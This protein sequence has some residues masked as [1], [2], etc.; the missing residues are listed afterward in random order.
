MN[1]YEDNTY[2]FSDIN[3]INYKQEKYFNLDIDQILNDTKD[4]QTEWK[5]REN[6]LKKLGSICLGNYGK[7]PNFIKIFNQRLSLNL[8]AQMNDLRSNL[9]K[10]ACRITVLC[11]K[12]L[13][14]SIE[15][16][17]CNLL[18][19]YNLYKNVSSANKVISDSSAKCI[20]YIVKYVESVKILNNICDIKDTKSNS[21]K[22][23][24]CKELVYVVSYYKINIINK[25]RGNIEDTIKC[26]LSDPNGDVRKYSRL[27]FIIYKNRFPEFGGVFFNTLE[28]NLQKQINEDE[29]NLDF[30]LNYNVPFEEPLSRNDN[31]INNEQRRNKSAFKTTNEENKKKNILNKLNSRYLNEN[32]NNVN[33]IKKNSSDSQNNSS[34]FMYNISK[35]N[36]NIEL[37]N[38]NN[39][40]KNYQ[41]NFNN[42]YNNENSNYYNENQ[43]SEPRKNNFQKE[44]YKSS[45]YYINQ[46]PSSSP[47]RAQNQSPLRKNS[48]NQYN[49]NTST[50]RSDILKKLNSR[51]DQLTILT[52]G[53]NNNNK[54]EEKTEDKMNNNINKIENLNNINEKINYFQYFYNDFNNIYNEIDKINPKTIK[55]MI[56]I[57]IENLTESNKDLIT[58]LIKNLMKMFFYTKDIFTEFDINTIV[59]L[60][61]THINSKDN[62]LIKLCNNLLEIIRKKIS[63]EIILKSV[64]ELL[65]EGDCDE[66]ICFEII[67]L[68]FPNCLNYLNNQQI[69]KE[70]YNIL[71][72]CHNLNSSY[73]EKIYNFLYQNFP[74]YMINNFDNDSYKNQQKLI[75]VFEKHKCYFLKDFKYRNENSEENTY[76]NSNNYSKNNNNNYDVQ[77]DDNNNVNIMPNSTGMISNISEYK[78]INNNNNIP[79]LDNYIRKNS[80]KEFLV[81]MSNNK[82][83]II[84]FLYAFSN[85][86]YSTNN[87]YSQNLGN[88]IYALLSNNIFYD[89]LNKNLNLLVNQLINL[90]ISNS[91][92]NFAIETIK[93]NLNLIPFKLNAEKYFSII[94]KY[95]TSGNNILI[96][97][98]LLLNIKYFVMNNKKEDLNKIVPLVIDGIF[99]LLNHQISDIR[100]H[101][102]YC[103][104]E[105]YMMMGY[106]FEPYLNK[107][108]PSQQNLIKLFIK[109]KTEN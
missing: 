74:E 92:N 41:M 42:I 90:L 25:A 82:Q 100:K 59:K 4:I 73:I 5:K 7:N 103:C 58:Q 71:L 19:K 78:N 62:G 15:N 76:S 80:I 63:N 57:H 9:M 88:L 1:P 37:N 86:I 81:Y 104:I 26:Y 23:A 83:Y 99:N 65:K 27:I 34:K 53:N 13:N 98:I 55:K 85:V 106:K 84:K 32:S 54:I 2:D 101:A 24:S 97:Q 47:L 93:E 22:I 48:N 75:Y 21:I 61:I 89:E 108:N 28:R 79:E 40:I 30:E 8:M 36:N 105:M 87:E 68:I 69:F 35:S 29:N 94:A 44:I 102:V 107:L 56:D 10:T 46:V 109:K 6:S 12:A 77:D 70:Y 3:P 64:F 91:Q 67:V 49:K 45:N 18:T 95:L 14:I 66:E 50:N 52:G 33:L 17:M 38:K 20:F 72:N 96:L 16:S 39:N 43:I 51:L 60:I 31:I 11:A